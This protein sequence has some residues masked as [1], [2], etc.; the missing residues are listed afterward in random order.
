MM[1][2][3]SLTGAQVPHKAT[4]VDNLDNLIAFSGNSG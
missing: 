1:L 3:Y 2:F 4:P